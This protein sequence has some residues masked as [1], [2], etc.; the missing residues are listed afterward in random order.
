[1]T[2][3]IP[4]RAWLIAVVIATLASACQTTLGHT[5]MWIRP[6]TGVAGRSVDKGDGEQIYM[7]SF[8]P[9][10]DSM[11]IMIRFYPVMDADKEKFMNSK[12]RKWSEKLKDRL[13]KRGE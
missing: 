6:G 7:E 3:G 13:K 11:F 1:M 10:G 4:I 12:I 9:R 5:S 2:S 8:E